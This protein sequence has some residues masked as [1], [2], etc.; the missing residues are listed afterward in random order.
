MSPGAAQKK[1]ANPKVGGFSDYLVHSWR[2]A[3]R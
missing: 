1:T 3:S 2:K